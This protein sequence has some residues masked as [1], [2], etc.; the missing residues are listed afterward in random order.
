MGDLTTGKTWA[1]GEVDTA[2]KRNQQVDD[3]VLAAAAITGKTAET[4]LVGTADY[5]LVYD[6]SAT[7]L[8]KA[9]LRDLLPAGAVLQTVYST[10]YTSS[11]NLSTLIPLD[12]TVPTSSEGD[13]ILSASITLSST[14]SKVLCRFSGFGGRGSDAQV[15]IAAMFR[16]A[17]C[18]NVVAAYQTSAATMLVPLVM[19]VLDA[20]SSISALTYTVRVGGSSAAIALNANTSTAYFGGA[21]RATLVLQ[22]IKV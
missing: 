11:S 17:T 4:A 2:T 18:V 10:E 1:S 20:P 8:R 19:D 14:S 12:N 5:A 22:E 13:Q 6:A 9:L 16:G 7:A 21:A 3:S 15:V